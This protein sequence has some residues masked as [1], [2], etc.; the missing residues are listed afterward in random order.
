MKPG[1]VFYASPESEGQMCLSEERRP[2]MSEA[3]T[4]LKEFV[5]HPCSVGAV[6][7][8]SQE[9]ASEIVQQ[10]DVRNSGV[11]VEFGAGTGVFTREIMRQKSDGA[12]FFTIEQN[13]SLVDILRQE[14]PGVD[15]C[16]DSAAELSRLM[17]E[18]KLDHVDAVVSGLPWAAFS[19]ELQDA[20]L[21]PVL[22]NLSE[23]GRFV[24]FAYLQGLLLP[25]GGRFYNKIKSRFAEVRRSRVVWHNL[26]PAFVYICTKRAESAK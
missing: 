17:K 8:S 4:F 2:L 26:P 10:A 5:K 13:E 22:D 25:A 24:T 1:R 9:L 15:V 21:D 6:Y 14:L 18:R 7:P 23:G 12:S 20:L 16:C 11:I 19:D 3:L